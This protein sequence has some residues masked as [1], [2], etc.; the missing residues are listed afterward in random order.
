MSLAYKHSMCPEVSIIVKSDPAS[1]MSTLAE[2][3]AHLKKSEVL[4]A[5]DAMSFRYD[6]DFRIRYLP[7]LDEELDLKENKRLVGTWR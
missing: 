5:L 2:F 6:L 1:C 3:Y 7:Q 4:A